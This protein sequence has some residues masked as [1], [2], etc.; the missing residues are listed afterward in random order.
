MTERQ[1]PIYALKLD[2]L[3]AECAARRG[4]PNFV[5]LCTGAS[6]F[7]ISSL[8]NL[9]FDQADFTDSFLYGDVRGLSI[10]RETLSQL[11]SD[12]FGIEIA[13]DRILITDGASGALHVAF[14]ALLQPGDEIILPAVS[15]P[16]YKILAHMVG[17]KCIFAPVDDR[18]LCDVKSIQRLITKNTKAIVMNSPSNPGMGIHSLDEISEILSLGIPVISD[19]VYNFLVHEAAPFSL[20][21]L[22]DQHFVV[23][24]LSKNQAAAG[25]RIGHAVIPEKYVDS[26]L[27][28][29]ATLNICTSIPAQNLAHRILSENRRIVRAHRSYV[30]ENYLLFRNL[31]DENKL[32]VL[33]TPEAGF[34]CAIDATRMR[35]E[36][37]F[38]L[39][40]ELLRKENVATCPSDDF[41]TPDR[42]FLRLNYSVDRSKL[43]SAIRRIGPYLM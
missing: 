42:S 9:R 10:L 36:S 13:S 34:F 30:R 40:M 3:L 7:D 35:T 21:K 6:R 1:H 26:A 25:V 19:E 15:F 43:S 33:G 22:T 41:G 14:L 39:A 31:C 32:R 2:E 29:K 8:I 28:I 38:D 23:N 4:D 11:Y 5:D 24:S 16:V 18:L 20:L 12:E 27:G 17:A 37:A